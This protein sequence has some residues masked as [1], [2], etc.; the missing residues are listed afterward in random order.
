MQLLWRT[1]FAV[2]LSN[3]LVGSSSIN[4]LVA[5]KR[6][7]RGRKGWGGAD[8]TQQ[9]QQLS[10]KVQ[11]GF[12]RCPKLTYKTATVTWRTDVAYIV[13]LWHIVMLIMVTSH[14]CPGWSNRRF[15][16]ATNN[17]MGWSNSR[18]GQTLSLTKRNVVIRQ[19]MGNHTQTRVASHRLQ[20]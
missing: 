18:F 4:T 8:Q 13:M 17:G 12:H 5:R 3:P 11:Q 2:K 19:A 20:A 1:S 10:G 14:I 15:D 16:L 7:R 9:F 6:R